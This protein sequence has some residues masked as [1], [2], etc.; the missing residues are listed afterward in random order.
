[1]K[2]MFCRLAWAAVAIGLLARSALALDLLGAYRLAVE[3]DARFQAARAANRA[4]QEPLAQAIAQLLPVV[5][6]NASRAKASTDASN[7]DVSNHNDYYSNTYALQIRQPLYR[8]YSFAQYQQAK[9]QA[10][11]ADAALEQDRENLV[12]RLSTTYFD[13]LMARDD[14]DL[15]LAQKTFYE[16]QLEG[17]RRALAAGVGTRTDIDDSQARYD[18]TVAHELEARQN[19]DFTRRRLQTLVNRPVG[20]L[21]SLDPARMA[22][23]LPNPAQADE[24]VARGEEN[25]PEL[26]NLRSGLDAVRQEVEKAR[27]GHYPTA[28]IVAQRSRGQSETVSSI[29]TRYFTSQ[30]G[31]QLNMPLLAGGYVNSTVRQAEANLDKAR[32]E[33]EARRREVELNI[34][35][36][37]QNVAEGILRVQALEQ[38]ERS[39]DQA[40][41]SNLK[42]FQA[43]TRTRVNILDAEQQRSNARRD[44]AQARYQYLLARIKLQSL[45]IPSGEDILA[46]INPWLSN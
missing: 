5:S 18:M 28:D 36:E 7:G 23:A 32:Q 11:A 16:V 13:A 24:W 20:Q 33:Y 1:M 43:G 35:K 3:N 19:V 37:F 12:Q 21:A 42:G 10:T 39:A 6:V 14:L 9:A 29:D 30:I 38:A 26:R 2:R 15:V 41:L 46:V 22:P 4:G 17:G 44:L 31:V 34:R 8:K 40:V 25:N 45:A 27:A